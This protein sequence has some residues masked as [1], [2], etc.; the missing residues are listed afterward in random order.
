MADT[1]LPPMP[2]SGGTPPPG[3]S[4]SLP[5][6]ADLPDIPEDEIP[7][8]DDGTANLSPFKLLG[9]DGRV[10]ADAA[11][12]PAPAAGGVPA[13]ASSPVPPPPVPPVPAAPMGISP[14]PLPTAPPPP[15]PP[16]LPSV[17]PVPTSPLKPV[18]PVSSA[19]TGSPL[20]DDLNEADLV[21]QA[22]QAPSQPL[23]LPNRRMPNP[24][25]MPKTPTDTAREEF[26][27]PD[28]KVQQSI[29]AMPAQSRAQG[30]PSDDLAGK[31]D[32]K[33]LATTAELLAKKP[34]TA[35]PMAMPVVPP[36]PPLPGKNPAQLIKPLPTAPP[37]PPIPAA[38]PLGAP[39]K[40]PSVPLTAAP[41]RSNSVF[42][43]IGLVVALV[44]LLGGG[45]VLA[46]TGARVPLLGTMV[47]GL[48]GNAVQATSQGFAF[49]DAHSPYHMTGVSE[50]TVTNE[51]DKTLPDGT[52]A[53]FKLHV[54]DKSGSITDKGA[55]FLTSATVTT[56]G[57]AAVPILLRDTGS[58]YLAIFPSN[59]DT[60]PATLNPANLDDTLL[61]P[62]LH[63]I[64][65]EVLLK[66]VQSEESYQKV[67]VNQKPAAAYA[68]T[69][70]ANQFKDYFPV[71]ATVEAPKATIALAWKGAGVAAGEPL[72]VQFSA[73]LTYQ[74]RKYQF[75]SHW[76]YDS[77]GSQTPSSDLTSLASTDP[78][79]VDTD[80][81]SESFVS[82]LGISFKALPHDSSA[83][84]G[85]P[86]D[87]S[88]RFTPIVP[89]GDVI[90]VVQTPR[91]INPPVPTQPATTEGKQR[92]AQRK[93]DLQ[94]IQKAIEQYKLDTGKYPV[95]TGETQLA[96][97][98]TLFNALVPKYL[99]KMPIDPLNS[100]YYYAYNVVV[101]GSGAVTGYYLRAVLEDHT[102]QSATVGQMY[103]Y[104][105]LT[106]K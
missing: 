49:V 58:Q 86:S 100:T 74:E 54:E 24:D 8:E 46:L 23:I 99:T 26:R 80:L 88:T 90:E 55:R 44:L 96:G 1:P 6:P 51:K 82:R 104:Y 69:L 57:G 89:S 65:L 92:D 81:T 102:D 52:P 33:G 42:A 15:P 19:P 73:T 18:A 94:D 21:N 85:A 38:K 35:A 3:S 50:L 53:V 25:E 75:T 37:P 13:P 36:P 4:T 87:T 83:T 63:P 41:H 95:V 106:N 39:A 29:A 45:Y 12:P 64:P 10:K 93:Q 22:A 17:P 79:N 34:V 27:A 40:L 72:D 9:K 71:G 2:P 60:T 66:A 14:K 84:S 59:T 28:E 32:G 67:T 91:A 43:T 101:D 5:L 98:A 47:S 20:D 11:M 30:A 16:P 70:D 68:V 61:A 105:E 103:H 77:W 62:T 97:D 76:Q 7:L 48:P 78:G 31:L 56:N